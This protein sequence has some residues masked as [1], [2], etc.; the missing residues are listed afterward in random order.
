MPL[1]LLLDPATGVLSG[2]PQ[3]AVPAAAYRV[4]AMTSGGST[5]ADLTLAVTDQPRGLSYSTA[6]AV[7]RYAFAIAP[8][9]PSF[10]GGGLPVTFFIADGGALPNG[11]R[12]DAGTGVISGTPLDRTLPTTWTIGVGNDAGAATANISI[13]VYDPPYSLTYADDP[14]LY[15]RGLPARPN[16]PTT[17]GLTGPVTFTSDAG[18]TPLPA[19]LAVDPATGVIAGI[20]TGTGTDIYPTLKVQNA[21]GSAITQIRIDVQPAATLTLT[22]PG[23]MPQVGIVN[24]GPQSYTVSGS[25]VLADDGVGVSSDA[26]QSVTNDVVG[27][28]MLVDRSPSCVEYTP[29]L[30]GQAGGAVLVL[31]IDDRTDAGVAANLY[32]QNSAV[33]V[34][35]LIITHAEGAALK[36][37][38]LSGAVTASAT[39]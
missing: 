6:S 36:A 33:Q 27:K 1:G 26:C 16:V 29:A 25:V 19:G 32:L 17:T 28:V 4:L 24:F 37:A 12:L 11:L 10:D 34:P 7:Y 20:P 2:T 23:T 38:L 13:A 9:L 35:A 18:T 3:V 39:R 21:F 22:P 14:V 31:I 30:R 15:A 8:N 5:T